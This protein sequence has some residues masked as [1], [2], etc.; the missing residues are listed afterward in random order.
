M[1][2]VQA[3]SE[4]TTLDLSRRSQDSTSAPRSP[5]LGFT[6]VL[7]P[8]AGRIG[9]HATAAELDVG[10]PVPISRVN[11]VFSGEAGAGPLDHAGVSR[12]PLWLRL[13]G[14]VL[15]VT[16]TA[17]ARARIGG[18]ALNGTRA[19]SLER[20]EGRGLDIELGDCVLLWLHRSPGLV[21]DTEILGASPAAHALFQT[22][23]TLAGQAAHV[24]LC[25]ESGVGKELAARALHRL[26]PRRAGPWVT[27]NVAALP[28]SVATAELFGHARGAFTGAD[29]AREGLFRQAQGGTLFLD[30][31][32]ELPGEVQPLLLRALDSGEIQPLGRPSQVVDVRVVT[33][34]DADLLELV[35]RGEFRNALYQRISE[36]V[37]EIPPL[38]ERPVDAALLFMRELDRALDRLGGAGRLRAGPRDAPWLSPALLRQ[39]LARPLQG[40]A[41]ELRRLATQLA[42]HAHDLPVARFPETRDGESAPAVEAD[43]L[44]PEKVTAALRAADRVTAV[45]ARSL[46]VSRNT[47]VSYLR[48]T[49]GFRLAGDLDTPTIRATLDEHDGSV[50]AAAEALLVSLHGLKLRMSQLGMP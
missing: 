11:P 23:T 32:G 39:V 7:H 4:I 12:T 15:E 28:P 14:G 20:L 27:V 19:V 17:E 2:K 24:L 35:A 29:M 30:E 50:E 3:P 6:V 43:G 31:V 5:P 49:P 13:R 21:V 36:V 47:L 41:R 9:A 44:T 48:V 22:L 38:R 10:L 26:G 8:E 45:A 16:A 33:A 18:E 37:V 34:T 25:G 42:L 40:N 46:G 1:I